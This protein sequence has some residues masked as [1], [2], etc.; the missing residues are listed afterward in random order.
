MWHHQGSNLWRHI[1]TG[2]QECSASW[3]HLKILTIF[4]EVVILCFFRVNL[5][6]TNNQLTKD[7]CVYIVRSVSQSFS[8]VTFSLKKCPIFSFFCADGNGDCSSLDP[9]LKGWVPL[10]TMCLALW[11]T[12]PPKKGELGRACNLGLC[13]GRLDIRGGQSPRGT[14]AV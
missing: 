13:T 11:N 4:C 1:S 3:L 14:D 5:W 2:A 12:A 7:R 9:S 6:N 8:F 10:P